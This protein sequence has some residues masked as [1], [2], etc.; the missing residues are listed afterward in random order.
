MRRL[1]LIAVAALSCHGFHPAYGKPPVPGPFLDAQ[2]VT[3]KVN[4]FNVARWK[5]LV[6]GIE[7]GQIDAS[8]VQFGVWELAPRAT[9]HGHKH[10]APEIY[11]ILDGR[12]L[13]SV[14]EE[15]REVAEGSTIYTKPGEVHKMVNLTD[16]PVR[17]VWFWWAPGGDAD[18]FRAPY[19]FTEPAPAQPAGARFEDPSERRY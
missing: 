14:G 11:F 7:G 5:T 6:G 9:Y 19:E 10:A 17:A 4:E 8:D 18:V 3:W 13:W 15:S 2:E 1:L 12:A 16:E